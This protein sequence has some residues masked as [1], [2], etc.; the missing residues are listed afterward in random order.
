MCPGGIIAPASTNEGELVVNGW[1]PSKRDNPYANSGMV[2]TVDEQDFAKYGFTGPLA[3]MQFQQMVE[4]KAWNAGGGKLKAPAQRMTD[5]TNR[6]LSDSLP[7]CSY[8]PGVTSA[9]LHEVLPVEVYQ[10]LSK[11]FISFGKKMK[12]YYTED[13]IVT[14]TE[15]RTSSPVRIPRDKDTLQHTQIKG[16][17]PCAEGAGYAGGIISAAMDGERVGGAAIEYCKK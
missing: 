1:S 13:A 5:F 9:L 10:S 11:G 4:Q 6:K 14:A 16:L 2:V 7:E 15:S 3:A 8:L 17:F 12:G